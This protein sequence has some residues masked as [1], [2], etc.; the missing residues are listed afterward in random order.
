MKIENTQYQ[1]ITYNGV[2]YQR[3]GA[4]AWWL[5]DGLQLKAISDGM[6]SML[7]EGYKAQVGIIV[8]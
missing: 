8:D 5:E 4:N 7:E 2:I 1:R 3:Y 6:Q